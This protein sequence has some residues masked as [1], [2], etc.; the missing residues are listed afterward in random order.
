[1]A[2][3]EGEADG[4]E[5]CIRA[6]TLNAFLGVVPVSTDET[7]ALFKRSCRPHEI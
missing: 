4:D 7:V 3:K 2:E 6:I 5:T 1:M